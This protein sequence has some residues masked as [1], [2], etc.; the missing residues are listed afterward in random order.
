MIV[1]VLLMLMTSMLIMSPWCVVQVAEK[2]DP[3]GLLQMYKT[4]DRL[5]PLL[6]GRAQACSRVGAAHARE[7]V[8]GK[9]T[10]PDGDQGATQVH[11]V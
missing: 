3:N 1:F 6:E 7:A 5:R 11:N 4:A 10:L 2:G 9:D 8:P